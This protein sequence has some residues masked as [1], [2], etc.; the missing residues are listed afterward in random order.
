MDY[1]EGEEAI[2]CKDWGGG[3]QHCWLKLTDNS[4]ALLG[5]AA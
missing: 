1:S 3:W 5:V 2:V 4:A